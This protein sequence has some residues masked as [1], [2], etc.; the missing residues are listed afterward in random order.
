MKKIL[1]ICLYFSLSYA[2]ETRDQRSF[3]FNE[4]DCHKAIPKPI[5]MP[6][7]SVENLQLVDINRNLLTVTSMLQVQMYQQDQLLKALDVQRTRSMSCEAA[8]VTFKQEATQRIDT[9]ERKRK[10]NEFIKQ[11]AKKQKTADYNAAITMICERIKAHE[12]KVARVL[13]HFLKSLCI[14]SNTRHADLEALVTQHHKTTLEE[15]KKISDSIENN[16]SNPL[17]ES[18]ILASISNLSN[19]N[20]EEWGAGISLFDHHDI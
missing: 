20:S 17:Q 2:M 8:L 13:A 4:E 18:D 15:L 16:S 7:P 9:E 5:L 11:E 14:N 12:K 3:S 6:K 10:S 19:E 1:I